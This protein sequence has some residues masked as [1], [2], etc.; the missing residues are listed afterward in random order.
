MTTFD[1]PRDEA[2]AEPCCKP[3]SGP[4][5][6]T[7]EFSRK[8]VEILKQMLGGKLPGAGDELKGTVVLE[9]KL[10]SEGPDEWDNRITMSLKSMDGIGS[11][12][13][14][15]EGDDDDKAEMKKA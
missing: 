11:M 6:P 15:N 4:T 9:V 8:H 7:I 5:Y 1:V 2:K 14:E 12:E 10:V 13:I 3:P